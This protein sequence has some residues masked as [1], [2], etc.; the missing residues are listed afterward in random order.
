V[1]N[2]QAGA[3]LLIVSGTVVAIAATDLV[4]PAIPG[5]PHVLGGNLAEA[6][7]VLAS[8][9]AGAALGLMIFGEL[10]ARFDQRWLLTG[11]LL[12]FSL[13][14]WLCTFSSSLNDLIGLRVV[15]GLTSSAAAVFAPGFLRRLYGDKG[16]IGALGALGSIESLVPA[17]APL[18]GV[19]LLGLG[20]WRTSFQVLALLGAVIALVVALWRNHLPQPVR[21]REPGGYVRLLRDRT[22]LR[23]ALSQACTLGALLVFVFGA[24]TVM[25]AVLSGSLTDFI[26]M[27]LSGISCFVVTSN[28]TGFLVRRFGAE[29]MIWCGTLTT[30]LGAVVMLVYAFFGKG[31]LRIVTAIFLLLNVGLALRGPPGF[32]RAIIAS[33]DDAR[34]AAVTALA[35]LLTVSG[36]TAVIAP[37]IINGLVPLAAG[38]TALALTS[39]VLLRWL[40]PLA[41]T[42]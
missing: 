3:F 5:L 20:G 16:S 40:P 1:L 21:V 18:L 38:A 24:P 28:M 8:F 2:R 25:T 19:G 39:A 30:A 17:F 15:Q 7:L 35:I 6:Q 36:G 4:L 10:G 27:Q 37:F 23:Y 26:V 32:H 11:S 42:R 33:R 31:N 14:S 22:F 41:T 9:T 29:R 13:V 34:G 12:G